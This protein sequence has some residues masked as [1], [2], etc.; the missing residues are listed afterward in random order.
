V[1]DKAGRGWRLGGTALLAAEQGPV[2]I[3]YSVLVNRAWVTQDVEVVI[4]FPNGDVRSPVQLGALWSEKERPSEFRDCVDVDLGFTPATNTLPIRCLGLEIGDQAEV[5]AAWLRWPEL[6]VERLEQRYERLAKD[7]YRYSSG[8]FSADL[9]VDE[10]GL[11]VDYQGLWRR[12][13][14]R[15]RLIDFAALCEDFVGRPSKGAYR[16]GGGRA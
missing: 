14:A 1:L 15:S 7:R 8:S 10:H 12:S 11:V 4:S 16:R 13:P 5:S 3:R 9:T 6:R 2:E